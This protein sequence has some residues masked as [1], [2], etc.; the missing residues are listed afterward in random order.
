MSVCVG[1]THTTK[2]Q[3][4]KG[5]LFEKHDTQQNTIGNPIINCWQIPHKYEILNINSESSLIIDCEKQNI[6]KT[7][8]HSESR[9]GNYISKGKSFKFITDNDNLYL[10]CSNQL[11]V[12]DE[13]INNNK[14]DD[15]WNFLHEFQ[16]TQTKWSHISVSIA[17]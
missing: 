9:Y 2:Q 10:F 8:N 16:E 3:N 6:V 11:F 4:S 15:C 12:F 17:T 13:R 1:N 5:Y 7:L 14:N